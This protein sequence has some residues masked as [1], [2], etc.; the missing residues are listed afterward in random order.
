MPSSARLSA[1][2][3]SVSAPRFER[4]EG[5]D[6][7]TDVQVQ[8]GDLQPRAPR[9]VAQHLRRVSDRHAELGGAVTGRDVSMTARVDVRIDADGHAR[10][11]PR[12]GSEMLDAI[13]FAGD[14][15]LMAAT[16]SAMARASSSRVLPTPVHTMSPGEKPARSATSSSPAEFASARAPSARRRRPTAS[17]ALALMA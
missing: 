12:F 7:G 14:S 10:D 1:S 15:T 11:R 16:P 5:G 4:F 3:I 6:L 2:A 9:H 17:V 13:D 8:A